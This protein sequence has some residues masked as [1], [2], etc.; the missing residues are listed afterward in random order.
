MTTQGRTDFS[1]AD[2]I[3]RPH[4]TAFSCEDWAT[5]RSFFVDVIGFKVLG[6]IEN[7]GEP[8]LATIVGMPGARCHWAMLQLGGVHIELFKWLT[9]KGVKLN[10]RQCDIGYTHFCFQVRDTQE[11]WKRLKGAGWEPVSAPVT[12]RGGRARG[13]YCKGPEG[14]I[15]EFVEY[16]QGF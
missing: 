3:E 6:E 5:A 12:L 2:L 16:P 9:P 4:H 14:C 8:E 11:A 13:F 10:L 7:R 15:I 1:L